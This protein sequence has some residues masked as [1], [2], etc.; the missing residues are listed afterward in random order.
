MNSSNCGNEIINVAANSLFGTF[1]Q[2]TNA[3]ANEW[4]DFVPCMLVEVCFDVQALQNNTDKRLST[5]HASEEGWQV[6]F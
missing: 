5:K 2:Y 3:A 4:F 1:L 6:C